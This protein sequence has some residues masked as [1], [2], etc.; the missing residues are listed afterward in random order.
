MLWKWISYNNDTP[1]RR[2]FIIHIFFFLSS[3]RVADKYLLIYG[4]TVKSF[5][6]A[7]LHEIKSCKAGRTNERLVERDS[8]SRWLCLL[9]CIV[10]C[11]NDI[12]TPWRTQR[13]SLVRPPHAYSLF[14]MLICRSSLFFLCRSHSLHFTWRIHSHTLSYFF[15]FFI[16]N[17]SHNDAARG[18]W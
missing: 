5:T 2:V 1:S 11:Q 13:F 8:F 9:Q 14:L 3:D 4:R 12:Y 10:C 16:L 7:Y 18:W 15:L 6:F 17:R